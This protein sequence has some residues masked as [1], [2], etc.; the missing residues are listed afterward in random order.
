MICKD[1]CK[2]CCRDQIQRLAELLNTDAEPVLEAFDK[3]FE[4]G[5][6]KTAP[7]YAEFIFNAFNEKT[8]V[9]DPYKDIKIESNL[10]ATLV[11]LSVS[12]IV[13]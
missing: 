11:L 8:G 6:I 12:N 5:E 1:A 13:L 9:D 2:K 3:E 4:K 10:E 7:E